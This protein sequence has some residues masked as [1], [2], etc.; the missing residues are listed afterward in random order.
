MKT[1]IEE[2]LLVY[3]VVTN[4]DTEAFAKLYDFYVEPIYRFVFFKLSNKEDAEDITSEVFLKTWDYLIEKS[5]DVT[6]FRQLVYRIARN[7]VVDVYRERARK[8]ECSIDL[9][10]N[11]IIGNDLRQEIEAEE[12]RQDL[13]K[14]IKKLKNEYQEVLQ[15]RYIEGLPVKDIAAILDISG[16]NVRV[17]IYRATK[18]LKEFTQ[19]KDLGKK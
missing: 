5:R 1:R 7:R 9:A 3:K 14:A 13:L 8:T 19:P 2:K 15:L 16:T 18:K 12:E 11:V 6:S 4:K 10:Q 17:I